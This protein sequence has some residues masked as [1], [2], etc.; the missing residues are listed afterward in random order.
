MRL[1]FG[2]G[3]PQGPNPKERV[4]GHVLGDFSGEERP[5]LPDHLARAAEICEAWVKDGLQKTMNRFNGK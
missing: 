5:T 3:K 4:I 1:R 2:I